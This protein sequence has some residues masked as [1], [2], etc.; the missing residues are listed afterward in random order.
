MSYDDGR[1]QDRRLVEIFNKNGIRG[2]FHLNGTGFFENHSMVPDA[3]FVPLDEIAELYRGHEISCH[4]WSHPY[5]ES[6]PDAQMDFEIRENKRELEEHAGYIMR[7]MSYPF[8]SY[9]DSIIR[10]CRAAG[11]MYSRAVRSTWAFDLPNDFMIWEPTCHH[12]ELAEWKTLK[13]NFLAPLP[14]DKMRLLYVWGHSYEFDAAGNWDVIENF[15][16]EFGGLDE[17]WYATNIE[18]YDYITALRSLVINGE[19]TMAY[20]PS[21]VK[22]W[23]SV[24]D[25]PVVINP[26]ETL[27]L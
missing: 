8:G 17:I 21:S 18:I 10:I 12:S 4:T 22:L 16:T 14:G 1:V 7:G 19:C 9:S 3:E 24:D 26:C 2:T 27:K 6:L 5:P 25:E 20:N 11:M 13:K 23:L 15:C